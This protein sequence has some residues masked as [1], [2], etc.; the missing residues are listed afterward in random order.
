MRLKIYLKI[1]K[2]YQNIYEFY[3]KI[4]K[5]FCDENDIK[6]YSTYNEGKA[7]V[8]ER[9]NRTFK[10]WM[11]K[12]FTKQGNQKWLHLINPLLE[13]YNNKVHSS[14]GVSPIEAS[15]KP[16]LV[17]EK[18]VELNIIKIPKFSI[19]DYVRIYKKKKHFEKGYTHKWTNEMFI[20][21]KISYTNPITYGVKDLNNENILGQ[22][23]KEEL[24]KSNYI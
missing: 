22:F 7:V 11:W 8:I 19:G 17:T 4:F 15:E 13:K 9:F 21:N 12:E 5:S 24:Q 6:I 18:E 1:I 10:T 23:Y 3:N 14:I 2:E 16:E 20:V